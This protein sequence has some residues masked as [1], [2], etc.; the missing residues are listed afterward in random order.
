[1]EVFS[2]ISTSLIKKH[3]AKLEK[4]DLIILDGNPPI[5]TMRTVLD[6][7]ANFGKP[8]MYNLLDKEILYCIYYICIYGIYYIPRKL[9]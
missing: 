1:M 7:A 4:A 3:Q 6:M 9:E 8:G 5:E 2:Q